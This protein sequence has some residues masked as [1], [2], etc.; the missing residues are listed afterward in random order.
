MVQR[1]LLLPLAALWVCGGMGCGKKVG[2]AKSP[3]GSNL[4]DRELFFG[5]PALASPQLSPDGRW[6]AF[7]KEKDGILNVHL[8][9]WGESLSQARI[10]TAEK[11]RPP[12]GFSWTRDSKYLLISQ[13]S[14]GDENYRLRRLDLSQ[15]ADPATGLPV[16]QEVPLKPGARAMVMA[17]PKARPGEALIQVNERDEKYF[18]VERLSLETLQRTPVW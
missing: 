8:V 12:A 9:G 10:I 14:G 1:C 13:D 7:L 2:M 17:L 18:D 4:I 11:A 16:A 5:N 6:V 3:N 15:P